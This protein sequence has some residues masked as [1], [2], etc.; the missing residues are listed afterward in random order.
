ME[1]LP[2]RAEE[3]E[4]AKEEGID[5]QAADTTPSQILGDENGYVN[6]HEVHRDGAGRAGRLRPPPPHRQV[7]GS[8]F[9]LDV[10]CVIM[11]IGTSPNPLI[12]NPPPK[13]WRPTNRAA[14]SRMKTT[15]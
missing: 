12:R 9:V 10:D 4:H 14:L 2:A 7:Q 13:A 3:V 1:E 11:A 8:E 6:G 5:L 15:D